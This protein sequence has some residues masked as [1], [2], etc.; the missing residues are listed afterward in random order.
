MKVKSLTK[1]VL[2]CLV[3]DHRMH[4]FLALLL[5][6]DRVNFTCDGNLVCQKC[7]KI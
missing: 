2:T 7:Q 5:K 3:P 6:L 1:D 4:N